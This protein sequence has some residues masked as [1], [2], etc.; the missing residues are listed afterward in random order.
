M[1][2]SRP[3]PFSLRRLAKAAQE[4]SAPPKSKNKLH[5]L[6][7]GISARSA[8]RTISGTVARLPSAESGLSN[9]RIIST[10]HVPGL[11]PQYAEGAWGAL[12][13]SP[14]LV[15]DLPSPDRDQFLRAGQLLP[16]DLA[17]RPHL[18][19]GLAVV[20]MPDST[21]LTSGRELV[22]TP[23]AGVA[24]LVLLTR[25]RT[26]ISSDAWI[27]AN[28]Y[29]SADETAAALAHLHALSTTSLPKS[30]PASVVILTDSEDAWDGDVL[31]ARL[32]ACAGLLD[33]HVAAYRPNDYLHR[34]LVHVK[35]TPPD[36]LMVADSLRSR[37]ESVVT[38]Y[39]ATPKRA[40]LTYT[41]AP[42]IAALVSSLRKR[43]VVASGVSHSLLVFAQPSPELESQPEVTRGRLPIEREGRK[44]HHAKF[45]TFIECEVSS[46]F[47]VVDRAGHASIVAKRYKLYGDGLHW[48]ADLDADG[49]VVEAKH[50][51]KVGLFIPMGQLNA[52]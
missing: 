50:K 4:I 39:L 22:A 38:A 27:V 51:G 26:E 5:P 32:T 20:A 24:Q 34:A 11:P 2:V 40:G 48:D 30:L 6:G 42:D 49:S 45:G 33:Y 9:L 15:V 18:H 10:T 52:S 25:D 35:S 46:Y 16:E 44:F 17:E 43:L 8:Y 7:L 28:W 29:D 1:R 41:S 21:A 14:Q 23:V 12:L 13:G 37:C 3:N 19:L 47:Y 31:D 36:V